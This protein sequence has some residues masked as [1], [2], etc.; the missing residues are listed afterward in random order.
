MELVGDNAIVTGGASGIGYGIADSLMD[1]GASVVVADIDRDAAEEASGELSDRHDGRAVPV[2]CD[3]TEESEVGSMIEAAADEL[4]TVEIL[5]NN[6]GLGGLGRT[7]ELDEDDWDLVHDVCLKGTFLCTK[8]TISHMLDRDAAGS[9]VNIGSL[10]G[11]AATDGYAHYCSAKAGVSMFTEVVAAEAGQYGIRANAI[12][13]G[14]VETPLTEQSNLLRGRIREEYLER[15]PLGRI[16]QPEDVARVA[17]FLASEVSG[18][19]TGETIATDGGM[20]VWGSPPTWRTFR[21]MGIVE[22]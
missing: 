6:A 11:L 8:A 12:A 3:V 2:R 20:H 21:D 1:H 17:V 10:A 22:E 4:G 9:I 16:G 13:P 7:W 15:T 14:I 5:V 18:W 19:I